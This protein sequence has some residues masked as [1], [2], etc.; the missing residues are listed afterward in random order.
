MADQNHNER[1]RRVLAAIKTEGFDG[2]AGFLQALLSSEDDHIKRKI[3]RLAERDT[4]D[5]VVLSLMEHP[6]YIRR[7]HNGELAKAQLN[8]FI[9]RLER[10]AEKI[11]KDS[12]C[13]IG[14]KGV[15]P[16]KMRNVSFQTMGRRLAKL[17]PTLWE[18]FLRLCKVDEQAAV[19]FLKGDLPHNW[20]ADH[21][22]LDDEE[23][24]EEEEFDGEGS[25]AVQGERIRDAAE[26]RSPKRRVK[27]KSLA[28]I[29]AICLIAF[30]RSRN[31]N[32]FQ[33]LIGC[34]LFATRT[35]KRVMGFLN[36]L[37]LSISYDTVRAALRTN[38]KQV[39]A[40]LQRRALL[41]PLEITYDNLTNKNNAASE[42][43]FNKSIMY[44]FT[45]G[46]VI[47]LRMSKSLAKRLGKMSVFDSDPLACLPE[48]ALPGEDSAQAAIRRCRPGPGPDNLPG[49]RRDLLIKPDPQWE[50]LSA[51]DIL[52]PIGDAEYFASIAKGLISKVLVKFYPKQMQRSQEDA[53]I[54]PI[55]IPELYRVPCK[56]SDVQTLATMAL[57]E[58]TIEG[59]LDV[60]RN[61]AEKQLGLPLVDLVDRIIPI[62]GD[63]MTLVRI[64]SGQY[65][66]IRDLK[67]YRMLWAKTL[68]G[69]LHTRMAL[70]KAI[71]LSH[72]GR[73]D[74]Q[75]PASLTKFAKLLGRTKIQADCPDL[76]ASHRL[77]T[78]VS[79]GH[80]LAALI[81]RA[82]KS[83]MNDFEHIVR[84]GQ[85]RPL[86]EGLVDEML[87]LDYVDELRERVKRQAA[88][89]Y[90]DEPEDSDTAAKAKSRRNKGITAEEEKH[91]D[92]V[93]EN[94]LLLLI[95]SLVYTDFHT[96]IRNGDSGR[97]E[98]CL[99]IL[100]VMFQGM[101][102]LKNYRFQTLD[103]KA[104]RTREWTDEMRELWL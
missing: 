4:L 74:G 62:S 26:E 73:A 15:D 51:K 12:H 13:R 88:E 82:G 67:E 29:A 78:Q 92:I 22:D 100:C 81:E 66:R 69:M 70:I 102:K 34:Y 96:A 10:E 30:S 48:R 14:A 47:F 46:A 75:D 54:H 84:T 60:M 79:E 9:S 24:G 57:D 77:L 83:S 3:G 64:A 38:A 39:L 93:H 45:A 25:D 97:Q 61:I 94:A 101:T 56:P 63:Q 52:D 49:I 53:A 99:D 31:C 85:W 37:G 23:A 21:D 68:P 80:I 5:Q 40:V 55:P 72:M 104:S 19:D 43:L 36:H 76:N 7:S 32:G 90:T 91:Q 33:T 87:K 11:K 71:Y 42:T 98:K 6:R 41:Q 17:A 44:C 35:G 95:H 65:L 18:V 89:S 59:N 86:V 50:T 103:M 1:L 27:Q 58:S 2:V 16:D 28:A 20:P 8:L